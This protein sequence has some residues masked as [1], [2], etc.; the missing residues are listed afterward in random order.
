MP[1]PGR[2]ILRRRL[3]TELV[4]RGLAT[5]RAAAH[6][7]I[8][9]G[10]VAVEGV[11]TPKP[12]TMV[13]SNQSVAVATR[14]HRW[15]SR[16]GEKL[17]AALQAF[18]L[19]IAGRRCLDVGASTGGFTDVLLARG[20]ESVVA[21]DVGYG[22]LA[23]NLRSDPRVLVVERTNFR[24]VDPSTIGAPFDVIVVDVSF[25]GIGAIA[26]KLHDSGSAGTDLV[27]L[28]KPQFEV[29]KE[30]VQRGGLVTDPVAHR[31]AITGV[32]DALTDHGWSPRSLIPSPITGA[33]GNREFLLHAVLGGTTAL[34]ADEVD[35]AVA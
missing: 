22:Q 28:V 10:L 26:R 35:R 25:I 12:A 13:T 31:D 6:D 21:L 7:V 33:K 29:G 11:P 17:D 3:D 1:S 27:V 20:A 8:S 2:R 14:D 34:T 5:S 30:R 15:V 4:E 16:G 32:T 23:W 24:H 19:D 9:R 18:S